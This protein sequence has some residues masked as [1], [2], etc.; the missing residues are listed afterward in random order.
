MAHHDTPRCSLL[1]LLGVVDLKVR[2][3]AP[4]TV[5]RVFRYVEFQLVNDRDDAVDSD[6]P[7]HVSRFTPRYKM[8]DRPGTPLDRIHRAVEI[9]REAGLRYVYAGNVPG[10]MYENTLCPLCGA[11]A[12][13]RI[14]YRTVISLDGDRCASCGQQLAVVRT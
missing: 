14:G 2:D 3:Q 1:E 13:G 4:E 10:D 12:I 6:M 8:L 11:V 5:F 7:W 9:G